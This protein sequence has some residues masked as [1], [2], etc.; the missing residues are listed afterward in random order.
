MPGLAAIVAIDDDDNLYMVRSTASQWKN[1]GGDSRGTLEEGEDRCIA[2]SELEEEVGMK[3][4]HW[5]KLVSY[6]SAPGFCNEHMYLFLATGLTPEPCI[7]MRMN[8]WKGSSCRWMRPPKPW[9]A[10]RSWTVKAL[11]AYNIC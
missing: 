3:A 6:Y 2:P 10:V 5:E 7:W 9:L 8:S 1:P 11:S 4:K